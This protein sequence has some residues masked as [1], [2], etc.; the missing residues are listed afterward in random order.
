MRDH[1]HDHDHTHTHGPDTHTHDHGSGP[2]AWIKHTFFHS[3][4]VHEKVDD[5]L[6][7]NERGIRALKI[8]MLALGVTAI[9]QV[10]VVLIS[11]STALLADTIHNFG[12][13]AT[14]GPLWLA[15]ALQRRGRTRGFTYGYGRSEDVAGVIIVL[16]IFGSA[17]VAGYESVRKLI[18]PDPVT[19]LPWVVA[20]AIIG[21]I[22]NELVA[23]YRIR[24]GRQID[25]AAL[26]AGGQH[27]RVDGFTSLAVL[28]GA[29]GVWVG[30]PILDPI[31]GLLIT[32][33]IL[34]IVKDAAR[35]IFRRL[36]DG[37]EPEIL[38]AVEH[39]PLHVEGVRDVHQVRARWLGHRLHADLHVTVDPHLTVAESHAIIE[40]VYQSLKQ[41]V[42][43]FSDATIH[44]CPGEPAAASAVTAGD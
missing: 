15:F 7:S 8:S 3:H 1:D 44:V 6:Q 4:D 29:L 41:H 14:S 16:L 42:P 2:I 32:I 26:V 5:A 24:V 18:D 35:A 17:V 22:G 19:N 34:V 23:V 37:I 43:A 40:R 30:V 28:I 38:A 11:G 33:T 39:A 12:D 21:F 36:L 10:F 20:A 27:S 9:V 31:I 13:A 25:S